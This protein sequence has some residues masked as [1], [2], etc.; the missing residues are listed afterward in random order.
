MWQQE[1]HR[2]AAQPV[3][4]RAPSALLDH[5]AA[6]VD[7]PSILHSRRTGGFAGTAGEAAVQVQ[8][9]ARRYLGALERSLDQV[10]AAARTVEIIAEHL[11]S[12]TGRGAKAAMHAPAQDRVGFCAFRRVADEIGEAGLH[13]ISA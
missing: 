13:Y 6:D 5:R 9:R 12:R 8:P 10:N 1:K 2:C 4:R 11:V 3:P 7:Q